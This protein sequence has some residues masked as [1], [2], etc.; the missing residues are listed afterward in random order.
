MGSRDGGKDIKC[1]CHAARL[2]ALQGMPPVVATDGGSGRVD[3]QTTLKVGC[4]YTETLTKPQKHTHTHT[5]AQSRTHMQ[6]H[7][8]GP[9]H[10][11]YTC[12]YPTYT[13]RAT[14]TSANAKLTRGRCLLAMSH[15]CHQCCGGVTRY[16]WLWHGVPCWL[17]GVARIVVVGNGS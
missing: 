5:H 8:T 17:L 2:Q 12:A 4:R 14:G 9:T 6:G 7:R 15:G 10:T 11:P 16:S 1:I 3:L 13:R